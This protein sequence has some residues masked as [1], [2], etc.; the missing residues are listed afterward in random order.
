MCG[1]LAR[2]CGEALEAFQ[3]TIAQ[4]CE[5]LEQLRLHMNTASGL[6]AR[7]L[8]HHELAVSYRLHRKRVL[9]EITTSLWEQFNLG[10]YYDIGLIR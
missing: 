3:T 10:C 2:K 7:N 1:E 5:A 8:L 4:D 6:D 9:Q